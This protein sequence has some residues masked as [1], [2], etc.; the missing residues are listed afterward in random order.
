MLWFD[1]LKIF[2][3]AL[4]DAALAVAECELVLFPEIEVEKVRELESG[5]VV[6]A[7]VSRLLDHK[8][9]DWD[10]NLEGIS[11]VDRDRICESLLLWGKDLSHFLRAIT[12]T[13][14]I[15]AVPNGIGLAINSL[16]EEVIKIRPGS[17]GEIRDWKVRREAHWRKLVEPSPEF[18]LCDEL[19][20]TILPVEVDKA[21]GVGPI[22][23]DRLLWGSLTI[24]EIDCIICAGKADNLRCVNVWKLVDVFGH[25]WRF[26]AKSVYRYHSIVLVGKGA[27]FFAN[28]IENALSVCIFCKGDAVFFATFNVDHFDVSCWE[29]REKWWLIPVCAFKALLNHWK[30][31]E[32]GKSV[33]EVAPD[34]QILLVVNAPIDI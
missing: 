1:Q 34:H 33:F 14:D 25:F 7:V 27:S 29:P 32:I 22:R 8:V 15:L 17:F 21:F 16:I 18:L 30:A 31:H 10:A 3:V 5:Q 26:P 2:E 19:P 4:P 6:D 28:T 9:D 13:C 23:D 20:L 12:K 24:D 11:V